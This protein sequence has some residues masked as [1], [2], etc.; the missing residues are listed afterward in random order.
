[1]RYEAPA[2][3]NLNL[4]VR[5]RD[6]R[7]YHPLRSVVQTIEWCDLI[8]F[9]VADE[10]ELEVSGADVSD[11]ADNL[12]VRA[13]EEFRKSVAVPPVSVLLQKEIAVSA[14]LGGGSSDAAAALLACCELAKRPPSF[15][16]DIAPR[17]GADVPVLLSGGTVEMTGYGEKLEKMTGLEGFAV[18][19]VVPNFELSTADVYQRWDDLGEPGGFELP[20]RFLPPALRDTFPFQNDL[21]RAAVDLQPAL[22]DFVHDVGLLWDSA[23]LL[24]GTGPA[25]YGFFSDRAEAA[26]A[27][28][29]VSGTRAAVGVDLRPKGVERVEN[30]ED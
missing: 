19:V 11:G 22:G 5:S 15:A 25:C 13:I 29:S 4:L 24:T 2:K 10:D 1:M 16:V 17:I 7:G 8:D 6:E 3:I 30:A 26:E 12:V 28:G 21:Y 9:A 14:G 18:A 20:D 27:A 23:V